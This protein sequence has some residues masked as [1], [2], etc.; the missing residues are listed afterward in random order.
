MK[1]LKAVTVLVFTITALASW[2]AISGIVSDQG[3]G[4]FQHE[5][6]RGKTVTICGRGIYRHMSQEVAIQGVAQ[7]Y[8][9]VFIALPLL[10]ISLLLTAKGS[11]K[12]R[13]AF[14]GTLGYILVTYL[15][16]LTMGM[17]NPFFLAYAALLGSSFFAFSLTLIS[18][19][20][21]TLPA[22]FS[23]KTPTRLTGGFLI[24]NAVCIGF[25]WLSV[26]VPP[27]LEGTIYP[28]QLE[29]YTTLIVQGLDLGLLLPLAAVSGLLM[30]ARKP[31]GYLLGPVYL[32]FLSF[33]MIALTAKIVAMG[34]RGYP[35]IPVIFIMP[36]FALIAI[37]CSVALIRS[38]KVQ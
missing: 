1:H 31:F 10:L 15:F 18:F 21:R 9:T 4:P 25:L 20:V 16:Y 17:Y 34:M 12:A 19:N 2:A 5:S 37:A 14:A 7:D 3:P 35:I 8:V 24:F 26:V 28:V 13:Y 30:M 22:V 38:I 36:T 29:H 33:L 23:E 11:L 27:L 6:V 32:I